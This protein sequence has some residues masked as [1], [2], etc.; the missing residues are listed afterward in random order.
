MFPRMYGG[1]SRKRF[2]RAQSS[3]LAMLAQAMAP[4]YLSTIALRRRMRPLG[5]PARLVIGGVRGAA[6][7][8]LVQSRSGQF[9]RDFH[10][11]DEE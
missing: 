9:A 11:G 3:K 4:A 10:D 8:A 2:S 5:E 1:E 7:N 6:D